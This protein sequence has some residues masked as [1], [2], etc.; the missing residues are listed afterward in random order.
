MCW[1]ACAGSSTTYSRFKFGACRPGQAAATVD[2]PD[3]L[4]AGRIELRV[5]HV[6]DTGE[7]KQQPLPAPAAGPSGDADKQKLPE[8]KKVREGRPAL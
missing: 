8:G 7:R 6:V 2:N 5:A 3:D 4:Q 1:F